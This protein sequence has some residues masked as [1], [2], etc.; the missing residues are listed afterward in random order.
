VKDNNLVVRSRDL[1]NA[2]TSNQQF[3]LKHAT[4]FGSL[5]L[6]LR[7]DTDLILVTLLSCYFATPNNE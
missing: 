4:V 2:S 5:T 3:R 6:H 1:A 7:M